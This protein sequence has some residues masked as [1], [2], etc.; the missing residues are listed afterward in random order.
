[1]ET[2]DEVSLPMHLISFMAFDE[3][4][5]DK[6]IEFHLKKLSNSKLNR[7]FQRIVELF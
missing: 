6:V 5:F 3:G 7:H 4:I 2:F 1:M